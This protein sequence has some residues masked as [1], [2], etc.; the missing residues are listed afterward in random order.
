MIGQLFYCPKTKSDS[1]AEI[2]FYENKNS[3]ELEF[4][5]HSVSAGK[6]NQVDEYLEDTIDLNDFLVNNP[7][8]TFLLKVSGNSMTGAGINNGDTLIVDRAVE[9]LNGDIIIASIDG[10]I[11][12]KTLKKERG[13]IFLV[14]EN[15][16]YKI[17]EVNENSC[18]Q[19]LGVVTSM[20]HKFRRR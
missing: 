20:I 5:S 4:F 9:P 15:I 12:V 6:P 1:I 17:I 16:N 13:K 7:N 3:L 2:F 8:S 11:T 10:E 19:V 14:P 18:F